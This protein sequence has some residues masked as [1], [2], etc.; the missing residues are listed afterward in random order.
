M[1][2]LEVGFYF[3]RTQ[4]AIV[5]RVNLYIC[6]EVLQCVRFIN[7]FVGWFVCLFV[8]SFICVRVCVYLFIGCALS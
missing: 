7:V 1:G 5:D 4:C 8:H 2:N 3:I 6:A